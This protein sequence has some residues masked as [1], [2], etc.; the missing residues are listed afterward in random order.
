M[1]KCVCQDTRT[2][3]FLRKNQQEMFWQHWAITRTTPRLG[4]RTCSKSRWRL[5]PPASPT[6]PGSP[7]R[8]RRRRFRKTFWF[9]F[10]RLFVCGRFA[11]FRSQVRFCSSRCGFFRS[12][13]VLLCQLSTF[14]KMHPHDFFTGRRQRFFFSGAHASTQKNGCCLNFYFFLFRHSSLLQF[15]SAWY[16]TGQYNLIGTLTKC[17][18]CYWSGGR[19]DAQV[20][21]RR[22]ARISPT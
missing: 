20:Y 15:T 11:L 16:N 5:T 14:W 4:P 9:F 6:A 3:Y 17:S 18:S 2:E 19:V 1:I 12:P 13:L 7:R 22:K 21:V 8:R 10:G